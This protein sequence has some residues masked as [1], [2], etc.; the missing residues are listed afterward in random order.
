MFKKLLLLLCVF[1]EEEECLASIFMT[2]SDT[3]LD[4]VV[5]SNNE[6]TISRFNVRL[7]NNSTLT[8]LGAQ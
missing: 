1:Q 8:L 5:G 4:E 6:K 2:R 3:S 7:Q